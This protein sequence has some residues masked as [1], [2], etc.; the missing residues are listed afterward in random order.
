MASGILA[1]LDDVAILLD[2]ATVMSKVAV[3]KLPQCLVMVVSF[4]A[5]LATA[6]VYG[7]V[8]LLVRMDDMGF[9]LLERGA[10]MAGFTAKA[11]LSAGKALIASLP[12][13]IH[14]LGVIGTIAMLLVGGGMFVH[15]IAAVHDALEFMPAVTA[16]LS[17]G[18]LVGAVLMGLMYMGKTFKSAAQ[19]DPLKHG[20]RNKIGRS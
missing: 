14:L 8:A 12:R 9:Y 6:G 10:S 20:A 19:Q 16:E 13:I 7:L 2:D 18:L 15:S 5:L 1:I 4:I 11:T 3:K 17:V